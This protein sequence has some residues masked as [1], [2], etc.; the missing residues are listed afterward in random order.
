[1]SEAE[2]RTPDAWA[3]ELFPSSKSGR[4]HPELWRHAG[5]EALHRWKAHE[6]HAG[7]P[8]E[9]SRADYDAALEAAAQPEPVA[10]PGALS[11]EGKV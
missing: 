9:L 7:K 5:A 6:H 3:R 2:L 10:H 1:M 8:I 4:P 11:A